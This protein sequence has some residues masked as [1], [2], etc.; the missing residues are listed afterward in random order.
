MKRSNSY[1]EM[2][3]FSNDC[4]EIVITAVEGGGKG[5]EWKELLRNMQCQSILCR[6]FVLDM[7]KRP[8]SSIRQQQQQQASK[9]ATILDLAEQKA[10]QTNEQTNKQKS[11][12]KR[13]ATHEINNHGLKWLNAQCTH[14]HANTEKILYKYSAHLYAFAHLPPFLLMLLMFFSLSM[15]IYLILSEPNM[16]TKH[17]TP[18]PTHTHTYCFFNKIRLCIGHCFRHDVCL[19][20][21]TEFHFRSAYFYSGYFCCAWLCA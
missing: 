16:F 7:L 10:R 11:A 20:C 9:Q 21:W 3:I 8:V 17:E 14:T 12:H 5:M 1:R 13:K 19:S 6:T 15:D 2:K 4:W 18:P